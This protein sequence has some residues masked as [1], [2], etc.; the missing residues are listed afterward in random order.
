VNFMFVQR[1]YVPWAAVGIGAAVMAL[2][3]I[4]VALMHRAAWFDTLRVVTTGISRYLRRRESR[5]MLLILWL[6]CPIALA[7]LLSQLFG[8]MYLDRFIIIAAPAWYLLQAVTMIALRRLIPVPL[9][10]AVLLILAGGGLWTYYNEN[11][12]E[13]W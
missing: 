13:Q 6:V 12:K 4:V 7:F 9:S 11:L 8:W 5:L 2:G 1:S 10:I 3:V